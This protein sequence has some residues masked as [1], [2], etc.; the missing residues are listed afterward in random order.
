MHVSLVVLFLS[1]A[2]AAAALTWFSRL[3]PLAQ[4]NEASPLGQYLRG[5]NYG[6]ENPCCCDWQLCKPVL[7]KCVKTCGSLYG[8]DW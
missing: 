6:P 1:T 7:E 4:N 5:D 8:E 2:G 3:N